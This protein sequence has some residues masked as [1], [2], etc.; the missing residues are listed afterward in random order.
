MQKTIA[1]APTGGILS[2]LEGEMEIPIEEVYMNTECLT[3]DIKRTT[4]KKSLSKLGSMQDVA[5]AAT[6]AQR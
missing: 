5:P 2:P 3:S 1:G 6:G 4:T